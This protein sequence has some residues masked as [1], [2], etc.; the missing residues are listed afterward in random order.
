MKNLY[1]ELPNGYQESIQ[2]GLGAVRYFSRN[3]SFGTGTDEER[4]GRLKD[5]IERADAIVIGAGAG[6][7]TAAGLT[8]SGE[9]FERYFFDFAKRYGIRDIYSGGFYPFP[10]DETRWAWWA[11]HIY[12]NRY[13]DGPK[14][15]YGQ[16]G[17]TFGGNHLGCAGA[18]AVLDIMEKENL[19]ENA[20][21]VGSYLIDVLT[22]EM[23]AGNLPHVVDVR[24]EGLM[25]GIEL[26]IPYKE[27]RTRLIKEQ[28]CFTGCAGTNVIRLL[29][30]L[31]ISKADADDF[32]ARFKA[33]L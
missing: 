27:P 14:P 11:R 6:L 22:S 18:I 15:V 12:Y 5:E 30:P 19:V 28:H 7:S 17:T 8:Y 4:I 26:D 13:I 31:C 10:D 32:I 16:L 21:K 9:R 2:K 20:N 1:N 33:V 25:I 29:P 3:M 24:G 23:K